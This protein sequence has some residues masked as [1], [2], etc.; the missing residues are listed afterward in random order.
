MPVTFGQPFKSGDWPAS[1]GLV[2][3]DSTGATVPLQIDEISSHSNGSVR[4]AV[5]STKVSNL[6][7]NQSR[8]VNLFL[9]GKTTSTPSVPANPDWNL[10]LE[11]KVYNG[12]TLVSTLVATPQDL[13]KQQIASG[14]GKRLSG[15]VA[16]EYTVVAPFKDASSGS[17]H[18]HLQARLHV[19]LLDGSLI[20]TDMVL[21]NNRTFTAS[22]SNIT[23]ELTVKRN[24]VTVHTQP[25]FTHYHHARWHKVLWTG[26]TAP[27]YRLRHNMPYFVNSRAVLNYN[28]ALSVPSSV[29][30]S[31]ASDLAASNTK[32]M[33]EAQLVPYFPTTGA[34]P[35]IG[36]LPTWS[37]LYLLTQDDRALASVM[38]NADAAAGVPIH[39]RDESTG[40]PLD[41]QTRPD[42]TVRYDI[43]QP[44]VPA[45]SGSTGSW[46]PDR[47]HQPSFAYLPYLL[48]GDAF[49]LDEMMFWASWNITMSDPGS[50]NRSD[51]LIYYEQTR[52]QAWA[53][54][55]I[56]EAAFSAPDNHF[57][58][59]Y[60]KNVL[61]KNMAWY[62]NSAQYSPIGGLN[63][64]D[65][66]GFLTPWQ[67]DFMALVYAWLAENN[68][69]NAMNALNLI[70]KYQ[71]GRF[72]NESNGFCATKAMV[73]DV[74]STNSSGAYITT[75]SEMFSRNFP[76]Y[77][78]KSCSQVPMNE[79]AYPT[80]PSGMS[81]MA[82]ASMAAAVNLNVTNA[83]AAYAK[84]K[85]LTPALDTAFA[86]DPTWAVVPR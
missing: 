59:A 61:A 20:R 23:Y 80:D 74:Q 33:G 24:G 46:E 30:S 77:V 41:V 9:S 31:L 45:G 82:R 70:S 7:A 49:Y 68:E 6:A 60:F 1:Q 47:S 66:P 86:S 58:K 4:F 83:S 84:I 25:K 8:L 81:A 19:R 56:G 32:P 67:S 55:S 75:W 26:G 63:L 51:G 42:V 52:G 34:R 71:V 28:L 11:A 18:P 79:E 13:L 36:P 73:Y 35:D 85:A 76:S 14:S 29:L 16:N 43:S 27:S 37:V 57:L 65:Y 64:R 22:P 10:Q 54:R 48:T 39:Y 3:T 69:T 44:A 17:T 12:S 72:V 5:L 78:G 40:H 21:E 53:L 15:S 38:A 2:A 62:G 50:R